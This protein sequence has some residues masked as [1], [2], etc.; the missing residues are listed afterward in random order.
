MKW[1]PIVAVVSMLACAAA[2]CGNSEKLRTKGRLIKDGS[3]FVPDVDDYIQVTFIPILPNGAAP[4][5]HYYA[6]VDQDTG[7]FMPAG[8]DKQGMPPGKYRVAVELKRGKKDLLKGKFDTENTPYV[9]DVDA[10]TDQI[11]IDLDNPPKK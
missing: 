8:K 1:L 7:V 4:L 9:V 5:D 3:Q 10:S 6:D 2:G 11:E